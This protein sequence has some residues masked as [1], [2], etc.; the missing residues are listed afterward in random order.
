MKPLRV[1]KAIFKIIQ[2]AENGNVG[3]RLFDLFITALVLLSVVC[4]FAATFDLPDGLVRHLSV[5]EAVI[6]I[7]FTVEYV[8]RLLRPLL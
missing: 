7:V 4:V 2:P 1:K 3:S 8:L 6:S 5:L